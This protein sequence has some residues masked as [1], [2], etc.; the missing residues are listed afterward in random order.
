MLERERLI[1]ERVD[2]LNKIKHDR[3][4]RLKRLIEMETA[5]S[6]S[7]GDTPHVSSKWQEEDTIPSE[8]DLQSYRK[9]VEQ[10]ESTKVSTQ[11]GGRVIPTSKTIPK[12]V[13]IYGT[14]P[15]H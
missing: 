13:S 3:M 15:S 6:H 1:R 2:A 9:T 12:C 5:L 11:N 14:S 4:K 10:L 8:G 7:M